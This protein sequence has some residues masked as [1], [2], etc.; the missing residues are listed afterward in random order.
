M[1]ESWP[2]GSSSTKNWSYSPMKLSENHA[3]PRA[4]GPDI[5]RRGVQ[6][7]MR[8]PFSRTMVG[9]KSVAE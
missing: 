8:S 6:S 9:K 1:L 3:L 7:W 5:D 4:S 2:S